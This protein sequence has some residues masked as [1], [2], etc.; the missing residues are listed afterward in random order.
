MT[1]TPLLLPALDMSAITAA[2]ATLKAQMG[3]LA[4]A[5]ATA[6]NA[7]ETTLHQMEAD[8]AEAKKPMRDADAAVEA[9]KLALKTAEATR[10]DLAR[11]HGPSIR[12]KHHAIVDLKV[13]AKA[14]GLMDYEHHAVKTVESN[15]TTSGT[16]T[17]AKALVPQ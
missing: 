17:V 16:A 3:A 9:A 2:E 11:T 1:Q 13:Q 8:L 7:I 14:A 15:I 10:A 6:R 12:A 4:Q 5:R